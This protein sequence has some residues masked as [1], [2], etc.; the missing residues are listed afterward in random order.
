MN[1]NTQS[2]GETLLTWTAP[3]APEPVRTKAWYVCA[4]IVAILM[5]IYSIYTGAWTFTG[6]LVLAIGLYAYA[7]RKAPNDKKISIQSNGVNF[8][9]E[10]IPWSKMDTFWIV[11]TPQYNQLQIH[12]TEKLKNNIIISLKDIDTNQLN[13]VLSGF[14]PESLDFHEKLFDKISRICKL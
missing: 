6:V 13:T 5:L 7:H 14:I 9:G 10:L 8:E 11:K 4:I 1:T 3:I 2:Q 12:R